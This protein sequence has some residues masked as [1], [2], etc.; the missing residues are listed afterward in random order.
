MPADP[1]LLALPALQRL[2]KEQANEAHRCLYGRPADGSRL[3]EWTA[4]HLSLLADL[5]RPASRDA[6]ARL[7]ANRARIKVHAMHAL[8]IGAIP[9]PPEWPPDLCGRLTAAESE[10]EALTLIALTTLGA[11]DAR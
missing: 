6:V 7:A 4:A 10:A 8:I 9:Y 11:P 5:S 1:R 2:A 3:E